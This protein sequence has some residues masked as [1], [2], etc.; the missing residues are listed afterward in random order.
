MSDTIKIRIPEGKLLKKSCNSGFTP[1]RIK[2][3][4]TPKTIIVRK[5]HTATNLTM[6]E[7]LKEKSKKLTPR[8]DSMNS[9]SPLTKRSL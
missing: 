2:S 1:E 5:Q 7:K 6:S 9:P 8:Y 3:E 4:S